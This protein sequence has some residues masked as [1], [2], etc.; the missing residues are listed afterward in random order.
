LIPRD[1]RGRVDLAPAVGA[2]LALAIIL[3]VALIIA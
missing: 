2:A 1:H 3:A